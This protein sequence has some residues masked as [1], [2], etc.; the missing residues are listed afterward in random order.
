MTICELS[1][2]PVEQ[3]ACRVHGPAE[4]RPARVDAGALPR[5]LLARF[6]GVCPGCGGRIVPGDVIVW[7]AVEDGCVHRECADA[8]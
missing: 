8:G 5:P 6:S 4:Q 7:S 3:C 2:L 1:D